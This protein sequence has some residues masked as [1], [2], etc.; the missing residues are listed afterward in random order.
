MTSTKK[1]AVS[2]LK[3][4]HITAGDKR[5][6]VEGIEWLRQEMAPYIAALPNVTPDYGAI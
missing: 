5:N 6:I 2:L 4:L 3:G 1:A